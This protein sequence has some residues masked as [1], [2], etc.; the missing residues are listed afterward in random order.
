MRPMA[1]DWLN[2]LMVDA[3]YAPLFLLEKGTVELIE[4][5][6]RY[7]LVKV[8]DKREVSQTNAESWS[9]ARCAASVS[10]RPI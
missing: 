4:A 1:T 7:L 8:A 10:K 5:E 9:S 6:D 2:P 3:R